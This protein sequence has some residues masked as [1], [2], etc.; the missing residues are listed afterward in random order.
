MFGRVLT[1]HVAAG[2][3]P[4]LLVGEKLLD[5][6][7]H[8]AAAGDVEQVTGNDVRMV[9][10]VVTSSDGNNSIQ[11]GQNFSNSTRVKI[12]LSHRTKTFRDK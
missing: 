7:E 9:A 4:A 6:G 12:F 3:R 1:C 10:A 8:H 11:P 5:G 2:H